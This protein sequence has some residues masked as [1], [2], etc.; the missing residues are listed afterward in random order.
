M[1]K[2]SKLLLVI[3]LSFLS[4]QAFGQKYGIRGGFNLAN[5]VWQEDGDTYS[6][7]FKSKPGFHI[8]GIIEF[9]FTDLLSLETGLILDTK[10]LNWKEGD[11]GFSYEE[12]YSLYYLDVPV[13]LKAVIEVGGSIGVYAVAGPYFGM[14]LSGK[15]KW[16]YESTGGDESGEDKVEW[17]SDPEI[18]HFKR[19]DFGLTFGGGVDIKG[20]QVGVTYD[21]GLANISSY[22]DNNA[23]INNRVLRITGCYWFGK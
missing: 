23:K 17:G 13:V 3:L 1:R 18:D 9:P 16:V 10:G 6:A 21:L 7:D 12:N 5:Q 19:P 8:G 22:T 14:G 11:S 4:Y 2:T 20:I 15:S